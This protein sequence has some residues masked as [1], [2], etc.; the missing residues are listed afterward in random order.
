[1]SLPKGI[2]GLSSKYPRSCPHT[3]LYVTLPHLTRVT[4]LH[5]HTHEHSWSAANVHWSDRVYVAGDSLMG[6]TVPNLYSVCVGAIAGLLLSNIQEFSLTVS[7]CLASEGEKNRWERCT[8]EG[9]PLASCHDNGET[10]QSLHLL[11]HC[12]SYKLI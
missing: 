3:S 7:G 11:P 10:I 4:V 6:A 2:G 1:M 5:T 8:V 9:T 12:W